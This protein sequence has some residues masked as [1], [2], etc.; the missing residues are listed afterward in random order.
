VHRQ[1]KEGVLAAVGAVVHARHR[2]VG[3]GQV[4]VVLGVLVDPAGGNGLQRFHR[5]ALAVLGVNVA[6]EAAHV[7]LGG[8]EHIWIRQ[9]RGCGLAPPKRLCRLPKGPLDVSGVPGTGRYI[10]T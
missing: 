1:V 2:R 6:E 10:V 8:I 3:I 4:L 5:L 7:F 9:K